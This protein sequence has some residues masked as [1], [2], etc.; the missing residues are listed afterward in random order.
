MGK[1]LRMLPDGSIFGVGIKISHISIQF[2]VGVLLARFLGAGML[3][4]YALVMAAIQFS[5]IFLQFGYPKY[6]VLE[7]PSLKASNKLG[8]I[9]GL[10]FFSTFSV[11]TFWFLLSIFLKTFV[12]SSLDF[13][14]ELNVFWSGLILALLI[15]LVGVLSGAIH[16]LQKVRISLLPG[17]LIHPLIFALALSILFL[18]NYDKSVYSVLICNIIGVFIALF[19]TLGFLKVALPSEDKVNPC[20]ILPAKW[21]RETSAFVLLAAVQV[22]NYQVDIVCLAY[23]VDA[24]EIGYYRVALQVSAALSAVLFGISNAIAPRIALLNT[25]NNLAKIRDLVVISHKAAFILLFPIVV[26]VCFWGRDLIV[27][28]FGK[29]FEA[30]A[31]SLFILAIGKCFFSLVCF[32]GLLLSMLG[33]PNDASAITITTIILN[34]TLNMVLIPNFGISG[35]AAATA[36]SELLVN[37]AGIFWLLRR[38]SY[39][40][41]AVSFFSHKF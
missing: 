28:F 20:R 36:I 17:S 38:F 37:V 4:Q 8:E 10:I 35:A 9:K 25:Q 21:C 16:G 27:L 19:F 24:E 32:S 34:I 14:V 40:F 39:N 26:V 6:L 31:S 3:G 7:I 13:D 41:S 2:I 33:H 30:S 23:F 12:W 18:L 1:L 15:S 29:G 22:M 5:S 11:V